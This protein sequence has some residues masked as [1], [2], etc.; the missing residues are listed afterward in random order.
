MAKKIKVYLS[1]RISQDAHAWNE[2]VC[3]HLKPPLSV[4]MPQQHNPWN[5]AHETFQI[6]VYQMDL[7]AME[8]SHMSLLLPPYGRDCAWEVGWY[9]HA[10]KPLAVFVD[11]QTRWLRDWMVKGG[12]NYIITTNQRTYRRLMRD[13]ILQIKQVLFIEHLDQLG[14]VL[15]R[16]CHDHYHKKKKDGT[17]RKRR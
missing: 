7:E 17:R 15:Q 16:I 3:S 13:P 10:D 1:A 11:D 6:G 5:V 4:F 12:L 9:V 2:R 14:G 8:E